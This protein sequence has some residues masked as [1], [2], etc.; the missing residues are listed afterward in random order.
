MQVLIISPFVVQRGYGYCRSA[1]VS[2]GP[3][4]RD[5][6]LLGKPRILLVAMI[7]VSV[8]YLAG[9][10][11][12]FR[13]ID[14]I[15]SL[16]TVA[17]VAFASAGFNQFA[18]R[19]EDSQM[20]RTLDRPVSSGRLSSFEALTF[21]GIAGSIGI[22]GCFIHAGYLTG[23]ISLAVLLVYVAAYT[24]LKRISFFGTIAGA[25]AGALPPVLGW[26]AS[27]NTNLAPAVVLFA[28]LFGWQFPHFLAIATIYR[29]DYELV[30]YRMLPLWPNGFNLAGVFS[31]AYSISLL[32]CVRWLNLQGLIGHDAFVTL[33]LLVVGYVLLSVIFWMS[34]SI[35]NSRVLLTFSLSL[36]F[37]AFIAIGAQALH[38]LGL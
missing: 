4:L 35:R 28:F 31:V 2:L 15:I 17:L 23:L 16:G 5:Y 7:S 3:T 22:G 24:P 14:F 37:Y 25:I 18:E 21:C 19:R 36:V 12:P 26:F 9:V 34:N 8:G 1:A 32:P 29:R 27:G 30:G 11:L 20:S 33:T 6:V 13:W 10:D 38:K